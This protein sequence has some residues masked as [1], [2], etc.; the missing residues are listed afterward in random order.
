[1]LNKNVEKLFYINTDQLNEFVTVLSNMALKK[2]ISKLD[3]ERIVLLYYRLSLI[4]RNKIFYSSIHTRE[5]INNYEDEYKYLSKVE[6]ALIFIQDTKYKTIIN[7]LSNPIYQSY[8]K[9]YIVI[10][11]KKFIFKGIIYVA[12]I[13]IAYRL[14]TEVTC[15]K[16]NYIQSIRYN[17]EYSMTD[18]IVSD[19]ML[20]E[21]HKIVLTDKNDY[22]V[23]II[24][25]DYITKHYDLYQQKNTKKLYIFPR[26]N[27]FYFTTIVIANFIGTILSASIALINHLQFINII[28]MMFIR[29]IT[30]TIVIF[31]IEDKINKNKLL[32]YMSC[33]ILFTAIITSIILSIITNNLFILPYVLISMI[34]ILCITYFALISIYKTRSHIRMFITLLIPEVLVASSLCLLDKFIDLSNIY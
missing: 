7:V 18:K 2:I 20:I 33:L 10:V 31:L 17:E 26:K 3:E 6:T 1:M 9:D 14:K 22:I 21:I 16:L 19:N 24:N 29:C 5:V 34:L 23:G 28:L 25:T 8:A 30:D 32:I 13:F 15:N 12:D 4:N 27:F 11:D